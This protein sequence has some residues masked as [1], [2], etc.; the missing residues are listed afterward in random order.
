VNL[1]WE[2]WLRR[3]RIWPGGRG[4]EDHPSVEML[5]AYHDDQLSPETDEEIQ[6]HFVDCR[7]CPELVLDLDRFTSPEAMEA[8]KGDLSDTLVD[9]AWR[10]LRLRLALETQ[11]AR[12]ALRWLRSPLLAWSVTMLLTPC[13][14]HLWL[15]VGKLADEIRGF[16][17]PQL[18][19]PSLRVEPAV[20]V[21]GDEPPPPVLEVPAGARQFLLILFSGDLSSY[22]EYSL[23]IRT[24]QGDGVWAE[25]GLRK[26]EDGSFVI[27]LSRRFLPA[28]LYLFLVTG[29]A[30]GMAVPFTEE[31]PVRLTYR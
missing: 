15:R 16:E 6:E 24:V 1:R 12:S 18:N 10:R 25:R 2:A 8:A 17:V 7:E 3:L 11:P 29:V 30:G 21:R 13:A 26:S 22:Q 28:G 31:F 4:R 5:A 9:T 27:T 23:E 20:A 19:P 14:V